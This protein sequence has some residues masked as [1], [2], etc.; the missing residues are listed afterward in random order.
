MSLSVYLFV[1]F[2]DLL[3]GSAQLCFNAQ[4]DLFPSVLVGDAT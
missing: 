4:Q 3:A 2:L 1:C